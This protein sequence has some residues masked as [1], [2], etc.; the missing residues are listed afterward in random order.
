MKQQLQALNASLS[1]NAQLIF[2][3]FD[4][5]K[6][7][8]FSYNMIIKIF[9]GDLCNYVNGS[10]CYRTS[11]VPSASVCCCPKGFGGPPCNKIYQCYPDTCLNGGTCKAAANGLFECA[12]PPG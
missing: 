10:Y 12:C 1:Q 7:Y 9:E 5:F 11:N 8:I 3:E 6:K 2:L 4:F